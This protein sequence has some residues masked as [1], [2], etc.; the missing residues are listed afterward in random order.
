MALPLQKH[1]LELLRSPLAAAVPPL[2][3]VFSTGNPVTVLWRSQR[4]GV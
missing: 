1:G 3:A 2:P 4:R